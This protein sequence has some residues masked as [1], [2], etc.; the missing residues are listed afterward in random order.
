MWWSFNSPD[1]GGVSLWSG[2]KCG[3]LRVLHF[4]TRLRLDTLAQPGAEVGMSVGT[5]KS[6]ILLHE[7]VLKNRY[8]QEQC[9][10]HCDSFIFFII[11]KQ[12]ENMK[13]GQNKFLIFP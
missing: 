8:A 9:N 5:T 10:P 2:S 12:F 13:L 3:T 4:R 1:P 11:A 7:S 6:R